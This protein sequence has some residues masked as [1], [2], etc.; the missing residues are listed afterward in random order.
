M[1]CKQCQELCVK[2]VI[3]EPEQVR[4]AIRIAE[5]TLNEEIL[6]ETKS[7][8]DWN[9]YSFRECVEK[10]IWGDIVNYHFICKHC[11]TQFVLAAEA[12]HSNGGYWSPE[13]EKPSSIID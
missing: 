7:A 3:R 1:S 4:S 13:N 9:Q 11:G 5:R 10:M 2:Y 6:V 12:Y 8:D